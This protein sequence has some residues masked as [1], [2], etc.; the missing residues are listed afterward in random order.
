M[1]EVNQRLKRVVAA[2]W[3]TGVRVTGY[4]LAQSSHVDQHLLLGDAG[5]LFK[6]ISSEIHLLEYLA[7]FFCICVALK[8]AIELFGS[9]IKYSID[10]S[11]ICVSV[12]EWGT[13]TRL[14][15]NRTSF[16]D[17]VL[18]SIQ[19]ELEWILNSSALF[20]LLK[21][22]FS[23]LRCLENFG[24][25]IILLILSLWLLITKECWGLGCF[26]LVE[27]P[28][29]LFIQV[30]SRLLLI[31]HERP[32]AWLLLS[33][34]SCL[35]L[36]CSSLS[37]TW[38]MWFIDS[39]RLPEETLRRL[40]LYLSLLWTLAACWILLCTFCLNL[41][42]DFL[43]LFKQV[44]NVFNMLAAR[45]DSHSITFFNQIRSVHLKPRVKQLTLVLSKPLKENLLNNISLRVWSNSWLG[46]LIVFILLWCLISAGLTTLIVAASSTISW[47]VW[48]PA[49]IMGW[50]RASRRPTSFILRITCLGFTLLFVKE[51]VWKL[52]LT[53][54]R[55]IAL[56]TTT[57]SWFAII[58]W[59]FELALCLAQ[60]GIF[61]LIL[62][63]ACVIS[64]W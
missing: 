13:W 8:V 59:K 50:L 55:V 11:W 42:F 44:L 27:Y 4:C 38:C 12:L 21:G 60:S 23:G 6:F 37:C 24:A 1:R 22:D 43:K 63:T 39:R 49:C 10:Q 62:Y 36:T 3:D 16:Y 17:L 32:W 40:A 56:D 46:I 9:H 45:C 34:S 15:N 25:S 58:S 5:H 31:D 14:I 47:L 19:V 18:K 20:L 57:S 26:A 54:L 53:P 64:D 48:A 51:F 41:S 29:Q 7:C 28:G 52:I 33:E 30:L 2:L 61:K 35:T